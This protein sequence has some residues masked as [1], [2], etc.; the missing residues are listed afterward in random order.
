[1]H[2]NKISN[3]TNFQGK[4]NPNVMQALDKIAKEY[5]YMSYEG[6]RIPTFDNYQGFATD[7]TIDILVK[8]FKDIAKYAHKKTEIY[9]KK[10]GRFAKNNQPEKDCYS[11]I[12]KN[13]LFPE[14]ETIIYG[15]DPHKDTSIVT[16]WTHGV[17][18]GVG[19]RQIACNAADEIASDC[20]NAISKKDFSIQPKEFKN[21]MK[22]VYELYSPQKDFYGPRKAPASYDNAEQAIKKYEES[23]NEDKG[24]NHL[25]MSKNFKPFETKVREFINKIL[26]KK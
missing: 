1:M 3:D 9:A 15:N 6:L 11:F 7:T 8:Q 23:Y 24:Y 5:G 17:Y 14:H 12:L 18:I 2:I 21:R 19:E 22:K 10:I 26:G 16:D 25:H 13:S 20:L 4:L